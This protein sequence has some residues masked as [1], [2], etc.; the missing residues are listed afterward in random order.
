MH[1]YQDYPKYYTY[2]YYIM[3]SSKFN[4][5]PILMQLLTFCTYQVG[6][7]TELQPTPLVQ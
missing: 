4:S 1:L 7:A 2:L 6:E 5:I 3:T